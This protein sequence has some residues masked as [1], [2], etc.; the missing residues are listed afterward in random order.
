MTGAP[1]AILIAAV[2]I[3]LF[4][5]NPRQLA[6]ARESGNG[7]VSIVPGNDDLQ[8]LVDV[9]QDV[10]LN[11]LYYLVGEAEYIPEDKG[12]PIYH[13]K[14]LE[15]P[16]YV[17]VKLKPYGYLLASLTKADIPI[18]RFNGEMGSKAPTELLGEAHRYII[19]DESFDITGINARGKTIKSL[20]KRN[21][22]WDISEYP[23]PSEKRYYEKKELLEEANKKW[24][25]DYVMECNRHHTIAICSEKLGNG[26]DHLRFP[27]DFGFT[28]TLKANGTV[29]DD[30]LGKF[31]ELEKQGDN[32]VKG[33]ADSPWT[34]AY[35]SMTIMKRVG[36][37][38]YAK[39]N[40]PCHDK[41]YDSPLWIGDTRITI[42]NER[43]DEAYEDMESISQHSIQH[44]MRKW[45]SWSSWSTY[46]ADDYQ[47]VP[48]YNQHSCCGC[49]SGCGAVAWAMLFAWADQRNEFQN[50]IYGTAADI[51]PSGMT[52]A[53]E[54][55][56]E[57]IRSKIRTFCVPINNQGATF[58]W[59]M[60]DV[61]S[62]FQARGGGDLRIKYNILGIRTSGLR[63]CA[64]K[65]ITDSKRPVVI[66][67]GWLTHYP[68]A[69]QY[70]VRSR[71]RRIFF[72]KQTDYDREAYL[73]QGWGGA[74]N[75]WQDLK[76]WFC[77]QIYP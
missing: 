75:G 39:L 33:S 14:N 77:G 3:V 58:P 8:K 28:K 25:H 61:K 40:V 53:V 69:T 63:D 2:T 9:P 5:S 70:R 56:I 52:P 31:V 37:C 66:G 73:N 49:I 45:S 4:S 59:R 22:G 50:T 18:V 21:L 1:Q 43:L 10:L 47:K 23:M 34:K 32:W 57:D 15:E 17:E 74:G 65:A 60:D 16:M 30:A 54:A 44:E 38:G 36:K 7:D 64:R 24:T 41:I 68:V 20:S 67:T 29:W 55:Y 42:V 48:N 51:P 76:T 46:S 35:I 12:M 62:W 6:Y 26:I 27:D 72:I 19:Y 13:I 71:T 11:S